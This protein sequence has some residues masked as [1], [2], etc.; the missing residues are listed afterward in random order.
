[1]TVSGH[2]GTRSAIDA[3]VAKTAELLKTNGFY[4][5]M[6]KGIAHVMITRHGVPFVSSHEDVERVLGKT[7]QWVGVH[8][9]GKYPGYDG[10]Y[11]RKISGIH[12]DMKI[13]LGRPIGI[14]GVVQP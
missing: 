7:I 6:S 11:I 3:Y 2:D 5:E 1:M 4:G 10:W 13:M 8:P 12:E 9:E 14:A